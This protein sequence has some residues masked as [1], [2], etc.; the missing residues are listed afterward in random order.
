MT[1]FA[2]RI[3]LA[4]FM[5]VVSAPFT[6]EMKTYRD[7][8]PAIAGLEDGAT[9]EIDT[10]FQVDAPQHVSTAPQ[11][12]A[13]PQVDDVSADIIEPQ[14]SAPSSE[15]VS[16]PSPPAW[17]GGVATK[18]LKF[19]YKVSHTGLTLPSDVIA[20]LSF[21]D[22][23]PRPPEQTA[24]PTELDTLRPRQVM[25]SELC[26]YVAAVARTNDLPVPF[27]ANLIWQESS[28]NSKTVSRVGA[29]GIAQF[30]PGTAV[31]YGLLNPFEPVHALS[32]AGSFLRKLYRR[33]GNLGLAAAA[34]NAGPQ[35]VQDWMSKRGDLPQETRNYVLRITNRPVEDWLQMKVSAKDILMPPRAPCAEVTE[36]VQEQWAAMRITETEFADVPPR[37][38]GK[39]GPGRLLAHPK[40]KQSVARAAYASGADS[41]TGAALR[42]NGDSVEARRSPQI[43]PDYMIDRT[44]LGD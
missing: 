35:R 42:L 11:V 16:A 26:G 4:V 40:F 2:R 31:E 21:A 8:G 1:A 22:D 30:M 27:F 44:K 6:L 43:H 28:F 34:Y 33:F 10:A 9:P 15:S 13:L 19:A 24:E 5:L 18:A 12:G 38:A 3:V 14:D 25:R 7:P 29:Q 39:P 32:A 17:S 37:R 20:R 36:A 23:V 41:T